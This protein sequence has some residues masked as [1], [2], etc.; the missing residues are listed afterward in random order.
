[1]KRLIMAALLSAGYVL[2]QTETNAPP[3]GPPPEVVA[4]QE[5]QIGLGL[6]QEN[7]FASA[8]ESFQ[9]ATVAQPDFAEA[10]RQWGTALLQL[11]RLSGTPQRQ[12]QRLQEA[13]AKLGKAA[14]LAPKDRMTWLLWSDTLALIGDLP[15]EP[16]L[17]LACY[18]GAVEKARKAVELAP[19]EW[20]SY[21]KWAGVLTAKLSEFAASERARVQLHL[22]AASLYSNAVERANFRGD[23][24]TACANWGAAL[25]RAARAST[26]PDQKQTFLREAIEKFHR[27]SQAAPN[28]AVTYTMCGSAFM[29]FGKLTGVRNDLRDAINQFTISLSLRPDDAATLY[30]LACAHALIG[31]PIVAIETLKKCFAADASGIYSKLALKDPDLTSLRDDLAFKDLYGTSALPHGIGTSNPPLRDGPR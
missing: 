22:E 11:G 8:A 30:A 12:G 20:E 26:V 17:R 13:A 29:Q 16:S 6:L 7:N 4:R 9:R 25:V 24:G 23:I 10:Y 14:E 2:G 28:S 15:V 5:Y 31:N 19:E 1:M 3:Q 27:S 21:T 18:Q